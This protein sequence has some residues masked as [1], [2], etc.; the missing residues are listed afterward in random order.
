MRPV[1]KLLNLRGLLVA[2]VALIG[3]TIFINLAFAG[4]NDDARDASA[5][6]AAVAV[7]NTSVSE[8]LKQV[9][10]AKMLK[11]MRTPSQIKFEIGE[12]IEALNELS[13]S[14]RTAMCL[15]IGDRVKSLMR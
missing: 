3:S 2:V 7:C 5:I 4:D 14:D 9:L 12:E 1:K 15:A 11:V 8:D 10:Y 6:M 13:P